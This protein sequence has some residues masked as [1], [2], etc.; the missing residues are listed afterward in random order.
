MR[1]LCLL[2][3]AL[4]TAAATRA[5]AD[6]PWAGFFPGA[7]GDVWVYDYEARSCGVGVPPNCSDTAGRYV[8]RV[9]DEVELD[10]VTVPVVEGPNGRLVYGPSVADSTFKFEVLDAS[11]EDDPIQ[12][13]VPRGRCFRTLIDGRFW[14]MTDVEIGGETY[15]DRLVTSYNCADDTYYA[16]GIGFYK[17]Y[18]YQYT[19][20]GSSAYRRWTLVGA[21]VGGETYG[22]FATDAEAP[23]PR[24]PSA[25]SVGPNPTAGRTTVRFGLG[26]AAVARV[27]VLDVLGR[28]VRSAA[29]RPAGAGPAAVSIDTAGLPAGRYVVRVLADGAALGAAPLTVAR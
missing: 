28:A 27:D 1:S 24:A 18:F 6:P 3:V 4:T 25:V 9:V 29:A 13:G 7:V 15:E 19:G 23:S 5:Q 21:R 20:G 11:A 10:G 17:S 26:E 22:Q 8:Y 12:I 14:R 2:L 16:E